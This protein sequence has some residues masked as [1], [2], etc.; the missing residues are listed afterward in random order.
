MSE[1]RV[2]KPWF[3][4]PLDG[5]I[6]TGVC[7]GAAQRVA[8]DVTLLRLTFVLL[9]LASGIGLAGYIALWLLTPAD[10][11]AEPATSLG[12][13]VRQN[14]RGAVDELRVAGSTL[15]AGWSRT[16]RTDWP[17]PLSRRWIALLLIAIGGLLVLSSWGFFGWLS[18]GRTLGVA[19]IVLGIAVLVSLAPQWKE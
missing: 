16:E 4:R 2:W 1:Q 13:A 14:L 17:R 3:T 7:A 12:E 6:A 9:A 10:D 11:G 15:A 5:R 19:A 8:I 18:T